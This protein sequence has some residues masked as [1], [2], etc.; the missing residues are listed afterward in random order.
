MQILIEQSAIAAVG[1]EWAGISE[2]GIS[3]PA[4]AAALSPIAARNHALLTKRMMND[5]SGPYAGGSFSFG[6]C[7]CTSASLSV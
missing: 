3:G 1:A 2:E 7:S 5:S 4:P 6:Q